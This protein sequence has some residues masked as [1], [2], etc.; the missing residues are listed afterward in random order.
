VSRHGNLR[1][2]VSGFG[3]LFLVGCVAEGRP[4][5]ATT[6]SPS[7][8]AAETNVAGAGLPP[9]PKAVSEDPERLIGLAPREVNEVLGTPNLRRK[10]NKAE[11]WQFAQGSCILDLHLYPES[12]GLRVGKYFVRGSRGVK[13]ET[14]TCLN[15]MIDT[16]YRHLPNLSY[17]NKGWAEGR[18]TTHFQPFF[19]T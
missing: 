3:L 4:P 5:P 7:E 13:V 11:L 19:L 18:L 17:L 1:G 8:K 12:D 16:K 9:L 6:V 14:K 15:N 2:L 10:E